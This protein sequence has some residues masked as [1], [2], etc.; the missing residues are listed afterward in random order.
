MKKLLLFIICV[1]AFPLVAEELTFVTTMG[2]KIGSFN[3]LD[4][5]NPEKTIDF[6]KLNFGGA[7]ISGGS[8]NLKG[9][10]STIGTLNINANKV[11]SL[12]VA[13]YQLASMTIRPDTTLKGKGLL[14]GTVT[15]SAKR[16]ELT[17]EEVL[18]NTATATVQGAKTPN[19]QI[20]GTAYITVGGTVADMIWSNKYQP[21]SG[22]D[23]V[24]LLKGRSSSTCIPSAT[25]IDT[26]VVGGKNSFGN[27]EVPE[28]IPYNTCD[29]GGKYEE[30]PNFITS[31]HVC[32][33]T[34]DYACV[35]SYYQ[36]SDTDV[37]APYYTSGHF[38]GYDG[39]S[40]GNPVVYYRWMNLHNDENFAFYSPSHSQGGFGCASYYGTISPNPNNPP[41]TMPE[42]YSYK[43]SYTYNLSASQPVDEWI[44]LCYENISITP[45]SNYNYSFEL[46]NSHVRHKVSLATLQDYC[47]KL[48]RKRVGVYG[49]Y[50]RWLFLDYN[51]N[52]GEQYNYRDYM[53]VIGYC[54]VEPS[55]EYYTGTVQCCA[56]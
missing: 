27:W 20:T 53:A 47:S 14:A 15:S 41:P 6:K 7:N 43:S 12:T 44:D 32:N 48:N 31:R 51:M 1:S 8:I 45:L 42:G 17:V 26:P 33:G 5:V 21:E 22:D 40:G 25:Y 10:A 3:R 23:K 11:S 38:A 34:E 37:S 29:S 54:V 28:E 19:L 13:V 46:Y 52:T 9:N 24:Y 4:T 30:N 55:R 49:L 36:E 35:D 18:Y 39:A 16:M 56:D 50:Y 2:A